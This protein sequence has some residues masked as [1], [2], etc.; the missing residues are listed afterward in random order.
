MVIVN[1]I[2]K[3]QNLCPECN[4]YIVLISE[5]GE[6]VCNQCGLIINE[7][8]IDVKNSGRRAY[9]QTE[10]NKIDNYGW[11]ISPLVADLEI[12]TKINK[13]ETNDFN[14]KRIIKRDSRYSWKTKNMLIAITELKRLSF[15]LKIPSHVKNET[16]S[17][18][19]KSFNANLLKGRSISGMIAAC[20]Y[21][22]SKKLNIPVMFKDIVYESTADAVIIKNCYKALIKKF[23]LPNHNLNPL[24][25]IQRYSSELDLDIETQQLIVKILTHFLK[26]DEFD[27]KNPMGLCGG[28]IYFAAKLKGK[29]ITQRQIAK[30]VGITDLTLRSRYKEIIEKIR[31]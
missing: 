24:L 30:K 6:T 1:E 7:K 13:N 29:K 26:N 28:A 4:G 9:T 11:P 23:R 3:Y 10:K 22:V 2:E 14:L 5:R 8:E 31:L 18:Y 20:L 19:K 27:G 25:F 16:V 12:C 15:N 21:F 17:L